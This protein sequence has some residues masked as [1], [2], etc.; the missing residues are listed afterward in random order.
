MTTDGWPPAPDHRDRRPARAGCAPAIGIT[1][2]IVLAVAFVADLGIS[3]FL[4]MDTQGDNMACAIG[5]VGGHLPLYLA[6]V[7]VIVLITY[8]VRRV[9]R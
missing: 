3:S 5:L 7:G 1:L 9:T 4:C 6:G 2:V 8:V